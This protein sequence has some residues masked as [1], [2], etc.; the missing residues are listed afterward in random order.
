MKEHK[1]PGLDCERGNATPL[2][3]RFDAARQQS[4]SLIESLSAEDCQLQSM[5][6]AS[7]AKWHLAHTTWFFETFVLERFEEHFVPF[8]ASF[9]VLFN[10]YYQG[11]GPQHPRAQ[12]GLISRPGLD[13]VLD[14]RRQ[15]EQRVHAVLQSHADHAESGALSALVTLG[16]HHE[17]Q[18]QELLV[19]DIKHALSFNPLRPAYGKRWPIAR[20]HAQ[21]VR[22]LDVPGG[23][24]CI[25]HESALDGGFLFD[26]EGPRHEV[27][28]RDY[29]IAS[30][31]VSYGDWRRFIA[32]GGYR[33]AE[34]WLSL[35]WDWVCS[36]QR[37]AP[38]YWSDDQATSYTL[39]GQVA[40]DD[41]T[42]V[43]HLSYFEADAYARWAG[44]RL[45]SEAE[46]EHAARHFEVSAHKGHFSQRGVFHPMP[47]EQAAAA[48]PLQMFGDVWE[49]TQSAY[50]AYPGFHAATGAVGEYNGK[51]MCNQFVLRGGSCAT[52]AGH[53][54]ASYRN[55]FPPD[56][57]WQ[58]SGVRLA[59][60]N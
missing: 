4:R 44:A 55:F 6:D 58:F 26:N 5:P 24:V 40:I 37:R 33:R 35:G 28:L 29:Q 38:L 27:L 3:A 56:A 2:A 23:T 42:P 17:Q 11:V 13:R 22:W 9:R 36:G 12:R 34:L 25:G 20:V 51:F 53:V 45:P 8:D 16:L 21:A 43:P 14:Y 41:H 19:S 30:R 48:Q 46:W 47:A 1:T 15:V 49:W 57:Q 31:P 60:D 54:R 52:P 7:P 10:S 39:H 59:R 32:D 18:H 50:A